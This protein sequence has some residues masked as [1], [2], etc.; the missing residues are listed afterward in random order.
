MSTTTAS[1][2]CV[3]TLGNDPDLASCICVLTIARGDGTPSDAN[4]LQEED[5]A[6]LCV[7]MG[8]VH[9][10]GVPQLLVME[11]VIAIHSSKEM[12]PA[13]CLIT[14][15][16]VWH[17]DAIRLC[18]WPPTAAQI[19]D[20]VAMRDRHPSAAPAPIPQGF[21]SSTFPSEGGT[22]LQFHLA[23]W[24]LDNAQLQDVLSKV[25]LETARG[26]VV[27]PQWGYPWVWKRVLAGEP[28]LVSSMG[29]CPFQRRG[30]RDLADRAHG[31]PAPSNRGGC[32][33]SYQYP[34]C[35]VADGYP[36]INTFSGDAMPEKTEVSFK[37]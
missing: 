10:D 37:Q 5:I 8:Q 16:T 11:S 21:D 29:K 1:M 3:H 4:S 25:C 2:A 36:K 30:D 6:E 13:A 9:H 35:Q 26:E 14:T 34:C 18:T 32:W 31:L 28:I 22:P 15:A 33:M 20:Y 7:G 19:Q 17:G 27:A 23:F 24:D 12:L